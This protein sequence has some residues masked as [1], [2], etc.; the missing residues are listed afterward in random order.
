M[1]EE[2][3]RLRAQVFLLEKE[4]ATSDAQQQTYVAQIR[5]LQTQMVR[6][7]LPPTDLAA[8]QPD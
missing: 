6:A 7:H 3:S 5:L 2:R 4:R 8:A 1:R